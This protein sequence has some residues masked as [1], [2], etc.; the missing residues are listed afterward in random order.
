MRRPMSQISSL[1][2]CTLFIQTSVVKRVNFVCSGL[3]LNDRHDLDLVKNRGVVG[4][5]G[6]QFGQKRLSCFAAFANRDPAADPGPQ[7]VVYHEWFAAGLRAVC[8]LGK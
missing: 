7:V 4:V 2:W 5:D 8:Q 3:R 1:S 6:P